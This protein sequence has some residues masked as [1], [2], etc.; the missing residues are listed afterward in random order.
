MRILGVDPGLRVTGY[1]VI[2]GSG[3]RLELVEAGTVATNAKD[4]IAQR[5]Q[6]IYRGIGGILEDHKPGVIV[7]EK[8]FAHYAHPASAIAIGH[9]RAAICLASAEYEVPL[10][11]VA[12][13]RVKKAVI[14]NGHASKEQ[15]Q[16]AVQR[17][18]GL[19]KTP[20][21]ADVS[22]A[23]AIAISYALTRSHAVLEAL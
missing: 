12:S 23:L 7:L 10:V 1:G 19:K 4:G 18:L 8:L 3:G 15:V 22:D 9:A 20:H 17:Y 21:P 2:D 14:S 13:T 5:L 11:S 6:T 16:K